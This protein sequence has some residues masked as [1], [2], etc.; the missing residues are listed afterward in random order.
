M[1]PSQMLLVGN[2][3]L[4]VN[5]QQ[6]PAKK[7]KKKMNRREA[8]DWIYHP[9]LTNTK[10]RKIFIFVNSGTKIIQMSKGKNIQEKDILR[11]ETYR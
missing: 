4:T 11:K 6:P 1:K 9:K 5:L 10:E 2:K 8:N 3:I 7:E